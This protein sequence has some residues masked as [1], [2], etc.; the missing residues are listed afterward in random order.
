MFVENGHDQNHLYSRIRQNKH[1]APKTENTDSNIVKLPWIP[2]T[3]SKKGKEIWKTG[4]RVIFTSAVKLKNI[5]CNNKSKLLPNSCPGVYELSCDC[6]GD[7]I[8][9]TKKRVFTRSIEHQED[10]M[11]EKWEASG[12]TEHSK[13]CHRWF[14]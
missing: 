10:S 5:L 4:C 13:D 8:G 9:Q 11:A 2:I 6:R 14:N 3:G 12:A 7:Y 1:Q